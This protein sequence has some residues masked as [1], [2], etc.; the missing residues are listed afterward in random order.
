MG[1]MIAVLLGN[2]FHV[3]TVLR[4]IQWNGCDGPGP[5][6]GCALAVGRRYILCG[7]GDDFNVL[8][9]TDNWRLVWGLRS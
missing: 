8:L 3:V 5:K 1:R 4:R 2:A 9:D 7:A 6:D